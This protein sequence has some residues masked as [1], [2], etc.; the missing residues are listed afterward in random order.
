MQL[1]AS[2]ASH[3]SKG[4][5]ANRKRR[6]SAPCTAKL[7]VINVSE[8]LLPYFAMSSFLL[9]LDSLLPQKP[10]ELSSESGIEEEEEEEE[11]GGEEGEA[12]VK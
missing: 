1:P 4:S 6:T 7:I 3:L 9:P 2:C 11:G 5:N 12:C 10:L 8:G